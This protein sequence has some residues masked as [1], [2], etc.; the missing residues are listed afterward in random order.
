MLSF[1][2]ASVRLNFTKV[3]FI[4]GKFTKQNDNHGCEENSIHL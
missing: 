1:M 3:N 4:A 2:Q